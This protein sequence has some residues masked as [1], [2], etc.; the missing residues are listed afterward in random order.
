LIGKAHNLDAFCPVDDNGNFTNEIPEFEGQFV[1]KE[2]NKSVIEALENKKK[3][4]AKHNYNHKYPYDWRSKTPVI[5]RSTSQWFANAEKLK[6]NAIKCINE[7]KIYPPTGKNRLETMIEKRDEWCISRQ[8]NWGVPI[9]V[10]YNQETGDYLATDESI[11][12]II[13]IVK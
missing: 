4:I 13:S 2:G 7:I 3:I 10:F 12:H 5:I 9:P 6:E 8:R 1:L 11:Q